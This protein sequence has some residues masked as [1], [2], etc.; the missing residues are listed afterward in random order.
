[1]YVFY[2]N[3]YGLYNNERVP[4]IPLNTQVHGLKSLGRKLFKEMP[5]LHT[6]LLSDEPYYV[7]RGRR[8]SLAIDEIEQRKILTKWSKHCPTLSRASFTA[9]FIWDRI[10]G[11][12]VKSPHL[13][14]ITETA[15]RISGPVSSCFTDC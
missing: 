6:F 12:W 7:F 14:G 1:M 3:P 13:T 5:R 2:R 4:V 10:E 11:G 15:P 8:F 9:A